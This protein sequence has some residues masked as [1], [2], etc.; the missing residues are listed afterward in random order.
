MASKS[1]GTF[2]NM[3]ISGMFSQNDEFQDGEKD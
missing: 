2:A 1:G 3:D